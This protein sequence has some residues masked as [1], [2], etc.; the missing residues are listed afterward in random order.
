MQLS[1]VRDLVELQFELMST[2]L[3]SQF[4]TSEL[5]WLGNIFSLIRV[6]LAFKE[7]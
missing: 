7:N 2:E 1:K 6:S 3:Q 4:S 5:E